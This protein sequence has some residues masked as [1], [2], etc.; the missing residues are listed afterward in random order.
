[1]SCFA[2]FAYNSGLF[3]LVYIQKHMRQVEC[4]A[5]GIL[6]TYTVSAISYIDDDVGL[7]MVRN[8]IPKL[9]NLQKCNRETKIV[10]L[11]TTDAT[12]LSIKIICILVYFV[13]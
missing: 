5:N 12:A 1:M 10:S 9:Q 8:S 7:L 13:S 3:G 2:Q 4:F 6:V 11:Q